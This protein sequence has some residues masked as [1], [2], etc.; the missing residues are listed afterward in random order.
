MLN[1]D[2]VMRD[3]QTSVKG[4]NEQS[5]TA[6]LVIIAAA[7]V[8]IG[9]MLR[10]LICRTKDSGYSFANPLFMSLPI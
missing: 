2:Q 1:G 3:P 5:K 6:D 8:I 4:G 7:I 9:L 10:L